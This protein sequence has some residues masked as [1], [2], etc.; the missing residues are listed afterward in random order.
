[1][2]NS[3]SFASSAGSILRRLLILILLILLLL[4]IWYFGF[5]AFRPL[6]AYLP[7]DILITGEAQALQQM[8]QDNLLNKLGEGRLKLSPKRTA[9]QRPMRADLWHRLLNLQYPRRQDQQ[10]RGNTAERLGLASPAYQVN[11]TV[12]FRQ[13]KVENCQAGTDPATCAIRI[14]ESELR[15]RNIFVE[16]NYIVGH[17]W[18][19]GSDPWQTG[20]DPAGG[21]EVPKRT[22]LTQADF[23]NQWAFTAPTGIGLNAVPPPLL[24]V[25]VCVMDTTP[26]SS[27]EYGSV[28]T[29]LQ[30]ST[31]A[32]D[33]TFSEVSLDS[34]LTPPPALGLIYDL[35]SNVSN[36]GFFVSSLVH[37]IEPSASI[38]L[39]RVLN[40]D[41]KGS[42]NS[43]QLGFNECL[44][45]PLPSH[46]RRVI[47]LSLGTIASATTITDVFNIEAMVTA[48]FSSGAVV[49]AASGNDSKFATPLTSPPVPDIKPFGQPA[50]FSLTIGVGGT[51]A[52]GVRS[53]FANSVDG[54]KGDVSAPAGDGSPNCVP[55]SATKCAVDPKLC[56]IG[57]VT[58]VDNNGKTSYG[59]W[60]GTSFS[61]PL[62]AGLA[63]RILAQTAEAAIPIDSLSDPLPD[64]LSFVRAKLQ[65]GINPILPPGDPQGLG[66][67]NIKNSLP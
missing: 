45:H 39:V 50:A 54:G 23:M 59:Y 21:L 46:G 41:G 29:K 56:L 31:P 24:P 11:V 53:C 18:Q 20:S 17:P 25:D 22:P 19:T 48:A 51:N 58:P 65:Q 38:H 42:L 61:S 60:R 44:S 49:V 55:S 35:I 34:D 57:S 2:A 27:D 5:V 1:M 26:F 7:A 28:R 64:Y 30:N 47:N 66:K 37:A 13:Y 63:A 62:V 67:I 33:I 12:E 52:N 36:H 9:I 32:W 40:N 10:Q 14:L 4:L 3:L 8:D 16:H 43:L 6:G 15:S